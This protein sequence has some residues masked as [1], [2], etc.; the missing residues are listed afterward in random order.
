MS[1]IR[2]LSN[3]E[4]LYAYYT[5]PSYGKLYVEL[6]S[7]FGDKNEHNVLIPASVWG[8][9]IKKFSEGWSS[10][11]SY[12]GF[13]IDEVTIFQG[14][15]KVTPPGH[16]DSCKPFGKCRHEYRIR[17]R[18]KNAVILMWRVTWAYIAQNTLRDRGWYKKAKARSGKKRGRKA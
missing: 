7:P 18:W 6:W 16:E 13:Q 5:E 12:K 8:E 10:P 9:A 1:I 17:F 14:T 2:C 11:V 4:G 3:P 15:R